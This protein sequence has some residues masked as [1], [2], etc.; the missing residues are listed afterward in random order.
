MP[1]AAYHHGNLRAALVEEA[2]AAVRERGPEGLALRELARRVGVSHNAAY[3]HFAHRDDLVAVVA[4]H[5][6]S[7]LVEA[8]QRQLDAVDEP[9]PVLRAR[10]R[11]AGVGRAYVEYALAEPGLFQVAFSSYVGRDEARASEASPYRLLSSALDDLVE[12]GYLHPE[13][14]PGAE[15]LCWSTVHGFSLLRLAGHVTGGGEVDEGS[16]LEN[17]LRAVDRSLGATGSGPPGE[18]FL[19]Q[20]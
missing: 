7:G 19:Q 5:A 2:V 18:P 4:D 13:V 17:V 14:R 12:V 8:M 10:L 20:R 1:R 3:R 6:M 11:L 15:E 16:H 9:D